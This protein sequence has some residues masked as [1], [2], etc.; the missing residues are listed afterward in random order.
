MV[1]SSC[2]YIILYLKVNYCKLY[3]LSDNT[4]PRV[5]FV[6]QIFYDDYRWSFVL[7]LQCGHGIT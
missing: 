4:Y 5:I 1:S 6:E 7:N 2:K 3:G